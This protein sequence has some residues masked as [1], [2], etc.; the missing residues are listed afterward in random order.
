V[1]NII[2]NEL[3]QLIRRSRGHVF[4]SGHISRFTFVEH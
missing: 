2:V 1:P 3:I 4:L